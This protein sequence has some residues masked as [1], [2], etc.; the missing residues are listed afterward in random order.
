VKKTIHANFNVVD[1]DVVVA[2]NR[3]LF[4]VR[5]GGAI[6]RHPLRRRCAR[7]VGVLGTRNPTLD[8]RSSIG[9]LIQRWIGDPTLDL[10]SNVG[11]PIQQWLCDPTLDWRRSS[12][13]F[14]IQH[15]IGGDPTLDWRRSSNG[16]AIQ[17]W[18]GGDPSIHS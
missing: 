8:C 3:C 2:S 13:G 12:N 6:F 14:A 11:L 4:S 18:I 16:F 5:D 10:R 17:H 1:F 15:W 7:V 9:L